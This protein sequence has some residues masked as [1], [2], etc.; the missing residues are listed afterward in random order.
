MCNTMKA[1]HEVNVTDWQKDVTLSREV[2]SSGES[3]KFF[4]Y[5]CVRRVLCDGHFTSSANL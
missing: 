1:R 2:S 3:G 4:S 5:A